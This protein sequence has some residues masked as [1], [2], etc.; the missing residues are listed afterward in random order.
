MR[1]TD[2]LLRKRAEQLWDRLEAGESQAGA[3]TS[4]PDGELAE[5]GNYL[6][7]CRPEE[8]VPP[9]AVRARISNRILRANLARVSEQSFQAK[10]H[11]PSGPLGM[12][13]RAFALVS[14]FLLVAFIA[15]G[16]AGSFVLRPAG[17]G[18]Q[19]AW[20]GEVTTLDGNVERCAP[21]GSW[22][23]ISLGDRL[24]TGDRLRTAPGARTEVELANGAIFRL[25]DSSEIRLDSYSEQDVQLTQLAGGSYHRSASNTNYSIA[26]GSLDIRATD[27]AFT[28]DEASANG[29]VQV[30]CLYSGVRVATQEQAGV[31]SS[32]LVEG[33]KC[34]VTQNPGSGLQLQVDNMSAQDLNDDWLRWNR[35]RDMQ[36]ELQLGVLA[37]LPLDTSPGDVAVVPG[38]DQ[39][40]VSGAV[41]GSAIPGASQSIVFSGVG[42]ADGIELNWHVTGYDF[43]T[44]YQIYR[45]GDLPGD[46]AL[47]TLDDETSMKYLDTTARND[48][49]YVY[50]L[51]VREGD[52]VLA[53]SEIIKVG[54]INAAPAP[55]LQ[56]DVVPRAGGVMVEG[57]LTGTLPFTSYVLIRSTL[58][59]NPSYPLEAGET[60]IQFITTDSAISYWDG[61]VTEGQSYFYR[62]ML[63]QGDQV[64]L[65]S[66]TVSVGVPY[67]ATSK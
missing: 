64:I 55:Q 13:P 35:D 28:V 19:A 61:Q 17:G 8:C 33:E 54:G 47:F 57:S 66:N 30:M 5:L 38:G 48:G 29:D 40:D 44:G 51:A 20:A 34:V 37:R 59:S 9:E 41:P 42:T 11:H 21:A 16:L 4:F 56:L 18:T 45:N 15:G 46:S 32:S 52:L 58:R 14:V 22:E 23:P 3:G 63:C 36:R 2:W 1:Y 7:E 12:H 43:I 60:A 65:R 25:N 26:A 31:V 6:R 24:S 10:P 53:T 62:L 49:N 67:S 27:T 39:T 50:Q